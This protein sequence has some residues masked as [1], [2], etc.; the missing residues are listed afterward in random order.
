MVY[1]DASI[2]AQNRTGNNQCVHDLT[3]CG[4]ILKGSG[5]DTI[6]YR[7]IAFL[8]VFFLLRMR[9]CVCVLHIVGYADGAFIGLYF[10]CARQMLHILFFH[11]SSHFLLLLPK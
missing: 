3:N 6:C 8:F 1:V 2:S 4:F 7:I 10:S 11:Y 9:A 5:L